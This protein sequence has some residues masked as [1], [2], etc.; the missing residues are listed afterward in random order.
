MD[1][2]IERVAPK[3]EVLP[4]RERN[5][6]G[7]RRPFCL[8]AEPDTSHGEGSDDP[9]TDQRP[10]GHAAPEEAGKRLDVSA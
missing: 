8:Q 4:P 2:S 6:G 1:G 10:L 7:H 9:S 3:A 5:G